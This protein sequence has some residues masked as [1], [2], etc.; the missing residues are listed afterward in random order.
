MPI[1]FLV[2]AS[3]WQALE[4]QK[5]F[6]RPKFWVLAFGWFLALCAGM[7]GNPWGSEGF[8]SRGK[9]GNQLTVESGISC[10]K[11]LRL[12]SMFGRYSPCTASDFTWLITQFTYTPSAQSVLM[13]RSTPSRFEYGVCASSKMREGEVG[14]LG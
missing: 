9:W 1:F 7:A 4:T 8:G 11:F 3:K 5:S 10:S 13:A 6:T 14:L 12:L 2:A